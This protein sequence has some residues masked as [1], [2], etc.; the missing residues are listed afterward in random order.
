MEAEGEAIAAATG[1]ASISPASSFFGVPR[2][3]GVPCPG[4]PL[5]SAVF[6]MLGPEPLT[7]SPG[8]LGVPGRS[9]AAYV[10]AKA[11]ND[12]LGI[13]APHD[14]AAHDVKPKFAFTRD[15]NQCRSVPI[16]AADK[17]AARGQ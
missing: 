12:L 13:D 11:A 6:S 9:A 14:G 5:F 4:N 1:A 2:V 3:L 15:R 17:P 7:E 16:I 10:A 8:V